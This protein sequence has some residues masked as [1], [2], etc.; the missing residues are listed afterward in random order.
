MLFTALDAELNFGF[1]RIGSLVLAFSQEDRELLYH[2]LENG[3]K[4]GVDSLRIL[5]REEIIALE[6]NINQHVVAALW[7]PNAGIV[8][9]YEYVVMIHVG[10]NTLSPLFVLRFNM[11]VALFF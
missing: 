1:R 8:S 6:P 10:M 5:E 4:N 7:C 11:I 9:P 2:E 3:K